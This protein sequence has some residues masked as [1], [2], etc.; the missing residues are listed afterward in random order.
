MIAYIFSEGGER[1]GK[2]VEMGPRGEKREYEGGKRRGERED[3]QEQ[4]YF[5]SQSFSTINCCCF[6][7]SLVPTTTVLDSDAHVSHN[8]SHLL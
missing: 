7:V 1:R 5:S 6:T 8:N 3:T 2:E 4:D